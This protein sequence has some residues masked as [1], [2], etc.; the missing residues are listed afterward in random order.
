MRSCWFKKT[1]TLRELNT[2]DHRIQSDDD[3]RVC[4]KRLLS[5]PYPPLFHKSQCLFCMKLSKPSIWYDEDVKNKQ[6]IL[7]V[8]SRDVEGVSA[9]L[10]VSGRAPFVKFTF[11]SEP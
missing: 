10:N 9:Q 8:G 3:K 5:K 2:I 4:E 1:Y 7:L 11:T 6:N